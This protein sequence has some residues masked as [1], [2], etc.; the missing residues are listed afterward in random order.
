MQKNRKIMLLIFISFIALLSIFFFVGSRYAVK[1]MQVLYISQAEILNIE[2]ARIA[3]NPAS[4][5]QLFLGKP[6]MAIKYIEQA[7]N[8]MSKEG[9]LV[10]LTDSKIYGRNVRSISKEVHEEIIKNLKQSLERK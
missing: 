6:E 7:Q 1:N 4:D 3:N 2:K 8:R 5:K 10:L 9:G